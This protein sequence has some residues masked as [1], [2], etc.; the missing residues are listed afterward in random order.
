MYK[1]QSQYPAYVRGLLSGD[2]GEAGGAPVAEV[3]GDPI[4][5]SLVLRC[6]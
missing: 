6:V 5:K 1:R 2:L 3:I 4:R